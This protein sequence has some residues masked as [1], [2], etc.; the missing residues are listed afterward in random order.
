MTFTEWDQEIQA[1]SPNRADR[2]FTKRIGL[3]R[4]NRRLQNTNAETL[5]CGV[6][7]RGEDCIAVV[8][9]VAVGMIEHQKLPELLG[10]PLG[11]R[12]LSDVAVQDPARSNFHC[13][14]DVQHA[15]AR[16]DRNE[17]VTGDNGVRMIPNEGGPALAGA[18][19][20]LATLQIL[21]DG[22]RRDSNAQ[23]QRELI[24][25][26]LFTPRWIFKGHLADQFAD[27]FR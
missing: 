10:G 16:R 2:P 27:I 3:G 4:S 25:D 17:E 13:D 8:D 18:S 19:T 24:R 7:A 23:L 20:R 6:Q 12:V 22:S 1:F 11:G 14:E 26:S 9:D 5:Q 15:K 21:T